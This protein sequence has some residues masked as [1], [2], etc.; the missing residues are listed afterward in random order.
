MVTFISDLERAAGALA[1]LAIGD[2]LGAPIEGCPAP[3]RPMRDM[4]PG[5]RFRR[6]AG[7]TTDDTAQAAAVSESLVFCRGFCP[8]DIA[9][10]LVAGYVRHPEYYGPTSSRV[11]ALVMGG[12]APYRAAA[13]AHRE[14]GSSRSNGSVMRGPPIGIFYRGPAVGEI[15]RC[16]SRLTHFDPV[17]GECSAFLNRMVSELCRGS[18]KEKALTSALSAC[19][20][21]EVGDYLGDWEAAEPEPG[22]DAL[23]CTHASLSVFLTTSGF[24]EA[25]VTA[26]DLGGD[27][28]TVGACTGAL[29]GAWY[30]SG[31]IPERWLSHLEGREYLMDLAYRLF[32]TGWE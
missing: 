10:R 8:E 2:A 14:L 4:K 21:G 13:L 1:G 25:L 22:L 15:S 28:D 11:F 29:A 30:G 5:G 19:R 6:P 24:E 9:R 31:A 18:G 32:A 7:R 26:V 12:V 20:S 23:L 16:C 27:A 3:R 17:A